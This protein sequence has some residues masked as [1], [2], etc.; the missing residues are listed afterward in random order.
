MAPGFK[1]KSNY[2]SDDFV[3]SDDED[4]AAARPSKKGKTGGSE[5]K[6]SLEPQTDSS[7]DKYWEISKQRRVTINDFRGKSLISVREYYEKDGESLPGKKVRAVV[8]YYWQGFADRRV[9]A[10]A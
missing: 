8:L 9:R 7:G 6:P 10:S 5:F 3:A 1:R 4:A 2:K